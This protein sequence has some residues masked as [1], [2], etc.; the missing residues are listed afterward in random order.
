MKY[1]CLSLFIYSVFRCP[2]WTNL[3]YSTKPTLNSLRSVQSYKLQVTSYYK[4]I[5]VTMSSTSSVK[6]EDPSEAL[7]PYETQ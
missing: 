6:S 3:R 1:L 2:I 4:L 7:A 5:Q